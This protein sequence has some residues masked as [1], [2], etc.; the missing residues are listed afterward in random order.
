MLTP[1]ECE[2]LMR[3]GFGETDT[4]IG[5]VLGISPKTVS[6]HVEH[7]LHKLGVE[8]RTAAV[9]HMLSPDAKRH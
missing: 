1:R 5:R 8:T 9:V 4:E 2:V 6:K 7:I 3:V